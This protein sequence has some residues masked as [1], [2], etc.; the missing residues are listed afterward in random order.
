[1]SEAITILH[2]VP[3]VFRSLAWTLGGAEDLSSVR[4]IKLGGEPVLAADFEIFRN[5]FRRGAVF[6][7][8]YGATEINV[9]RQWFAGHDTPWP[10]A[11]P[12]G[13]VVDGVDV[14]LLDELGRETGGEGEIGVV[15][16][17]LALGYWRDPERT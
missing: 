16:N 2:S 3:S 14:V 17:T 9:M 13:H 15:S 7:V 1:E 6:H 8:G 11:S 4:M 5:R 12:L 10:G